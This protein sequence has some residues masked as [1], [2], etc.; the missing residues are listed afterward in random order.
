MTA[1]LW[2]TEVNVNAAHGGGLSPVVTGELHTPAVGG[3][4]TCCNGLEQ[5]NYTY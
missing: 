5:Q 2:S 4:L 3:V 1:L